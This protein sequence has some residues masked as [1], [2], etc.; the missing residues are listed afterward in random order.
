MSYVYIP[1]S[2]PLCG[3]PYEKPVLTLGMYGVVDFYDLKGV[4]EE[5]MTKLGIEDYDISPEKNNVIF[6]RGRTAVLSIKGEYAGVIGEVHPEVAEKF[7]CPERTYIGVIETEK[8][9]KNASTKSEYSPLPK[10]PAVT[11]DMALLVKDEILVKQIEDI[12]RQRAGKILEE[13]KLFDVYKGKQVPE[14]MK[15]VAYSIVFRASDRTLTDEDV[16]K[17]M[18]KI[19]DSIKSSLGAELR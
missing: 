6:H 1:K 18:K 17:A 4:V 10:F 2:L 13:I 5:L 8:L 9:V 7:E 14:G 11:R 12:I 15:S 19:L 3:L 16:N